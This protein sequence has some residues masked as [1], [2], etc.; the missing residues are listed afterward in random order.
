[1]GIMR[2]ATAGLGAFVV[3]FAFGR[4]TKPADPER[5][6]AVAERRVEDE[7][8][9]AEEAGAR[10]KRSEVAKAN[11]A[12]FWAAMMTTEGRDLLFDVSPVEG[13]PNALAIGVTTRWLML[14]R[15]ARLRSAVAMWDAWARANER[16]ESRAKICKI[17][18]IDR[19]GRRVGG[20]SDWGN[21]ADISVEGE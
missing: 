4:G 18:L 9:H 17:R 1:M 6:A 11:A 19:T 5:E 3:A 21:G 7:R 20:S 13:A 16:A 10:A 14:P 12:V 15:E 2:T 8:R